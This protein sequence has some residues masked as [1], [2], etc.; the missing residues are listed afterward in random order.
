MENETIRVLLVD[1]DQGD[2][3]MTRALLSQIDREGLE[4]DWVSSYAE[5]ESSLDGDAYD[6]YLVDYLLEDRSGLDLLR[7]AA[8]RGLHIPMILLTGRGSREVDLEAMRAGAADYLVKGKI[9]P[10]LLER[11]IRYALERH[12][13]QEELRASEE[14]LRAMFDHLPIGLHR[15]TPDGEFMEANPTLIRILGHPDRE[16]LREHARHLYVAPEDAERFREGLEAEG[17]LRGFHTVLEGADGSRTPVRAT[18]RLHRD[19][20][21]QV[22]Y[23]EGAVEDET[24]LRQARLLEESEARFRTLFDVVRAGI[25]VLDPDGVV[26]ETN[27]AFRQA[28][29]RSPEDLSNSFFTALAVEDERSDLRRSLSALARGERER[30]EGEHRF[31]AADGALLWARVDASPI[32][33][34]EGRVRHLLLVLEDFADTGERAGG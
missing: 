12:R 2:F 15:T 25:V 1:D 23:V 18:A 33:D 4:L 14:R 17:V 28:L 7:E 13:A 21:G 3:E 34:D 16:T 22:Q 27:P 29:G 11:S 30:V 24:D 26:E 32:E 20:D 8:N 10:P 9:D 6:L 31:L 19:P 5:A